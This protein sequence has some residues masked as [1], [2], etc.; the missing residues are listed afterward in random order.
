MVFNS[1]L[2]VRFPAFSYYTP[3]GFSLYGMPSHVNP[4]FKIGLDS[5]GDIVMP[6]T[7]NYRPDKIRENYCKEWCKR[8]L[9]KVGLELK[10]VWLYDAVSVFE[11]LLKVRT[12]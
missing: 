5:T 7:R 1:L 4:F 12:H 6:G 8:Y 2:L 9:P 11:F 3:N 10:G